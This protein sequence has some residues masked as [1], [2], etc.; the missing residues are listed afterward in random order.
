MI[1]GNATQEATAGGQ[2]GLLAERKVKANVARNESPGAIRFESPL[3]DFQGLQIH[4]HC[5]AGLQ[6]I[7]ADEVSES[8]R[9]GA[10]FRLI[11]TQKELV[12]MKP[13]RAF[14]LAGIYQ[15]RCF[16]TA[17]VVP[18]E[19]SNAGSEIDTVANMI[20]SPSAQR[21]LEAFTAGPIRYRL[22][23]VSRGHQRGAVR[24]I[25]N[26]AYNLQPALLNDPRNAL[27]QINIH[28]SP[29]LHIELN[30]RLR[31][32][33][34]YTWRVGDVP[35]AS[36]PAL[37]ASMARLAGGH[38]HDIIWD[39]FC[40]SGLELIERALQ[41]GVQAIFGT[42]HHAEALAV[43]RQNLAAA[44]KCPIPITL[45]DCDFRDYATVPG[46]RPGTISLIITNPPLGR[47]VPIPNLA[48]L[49]D[50]LFRIATTLLR[51]GGRLVFV[52]PLPVEPRD[53]TLRREF[54]REIDLGGFHA[55]LEKYVRT[56]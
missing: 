32:D 15:L 27:W 21:V 31:P 51:P 56:D 20:T 19:Y 23:F 26:R 2:L 41:G 8:V 47:R 12:I 17:G 3:M 28:D 7:L 1:G 36:H 35:A 10:P 46:L 6:D 55:H 29:K 37:A 22:E 52:N 40:G 43:A 11:E 25:A 38:D 4:L 14:S 44:L 50:D 30:P 5:R 24:E 39:P 53:R 16:S 9:A 45:A 42:D 33:P 13:I 48:R 18:G 34:R 49:I 54:R